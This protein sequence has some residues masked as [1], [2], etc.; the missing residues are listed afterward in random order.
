MFFRSSSQPVRRSVQH[1]YALPRRG[2]G[3]KVAAFAESQN[4]QLAFGALGWLV[5]VECIRR[6]RT[7]S[8]KRNRLINLVGSSSEV[9][10]R[11]P[12][13]GAMRMR[14]ARAIYRPSSSRY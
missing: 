3:I 7:A 6:R 2:V 11:C 9:S 1:G 10:V 4:I 5:T 8:K 14:A 12:A 13:Q